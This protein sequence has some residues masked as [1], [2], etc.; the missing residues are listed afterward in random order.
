MVRLLGV[1]ACLLCVAVLGHQGFAWGDEGHEIVALIAQHLLEPEVRSKVE[2]LLAADPDNLTPHDIASEATWADHYRDED[3]HT[4]GL[5]HYAETRFWHFVNV[6]IDKPDLNEACFG[7]PPLPA[8][9]VASKGPAHACIVD[10]INQFSTELADP[11]T[12]PQ[13]RLLAL[14]FLLHLLGDLH[15]PLHVADDHDHGG[16]GKQVRAERLPVGRLHHYWDTEFVQRLGRDPRALAE[17]LIQGIF[18]EQRQAW[19]QGSV[20]DW[21]MDTFMVGRDHAY[22]LLGQPGVDGMYR[23]SSEYVETAVSDVRAQLSKAGVR[24]AFVL[25]SALR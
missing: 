4:T 25:N 10:K 16:N 12:D 22:S 17:S 1:A 15:Q 5:H 8:G 7:H 23:L 18:D 19:A 9:T 6:E 20:P 11:A 21:A 24:L 13:E 14:K 2:G 3:W